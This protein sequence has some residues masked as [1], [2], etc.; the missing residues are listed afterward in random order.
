[1]EK[2]DSLLEE[3]DLAENPS[4]VTK[5]KWTWAH[6]PPGTVFEVDPTVGNGYGKTAFTSTQIFANGV[7]SYVVDT[8]TPGVVTDFLSF[9]LSWVT[10]ILKRGEGVPVVDF[11]L[12]CLKRNSS[13]HNAIIEQIH[14]IYKKKK[15]EYVGLY[16]HDV[17]NIALSKLKCIDVVIDSE[18]LLINLLKQGVIKGHKVFQYNYDFIVWTANKKKLLNAVKRNFSKCLIPVKHR[19]KEEA[20]EE[21]RE[22]DQYCDDLDL[23]YG[24]RSSGDVEEDDVYIDRFE[25]WY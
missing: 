25:S 24:R 12:G 6:F 2:I 8:T 14:G 5:S 13:E 10:H 7:R 20:G 19:L 18:A 1:M 22:W 16:V 3:M 11:N 4:V 21:Q 23:D 17:I 15:N 9:N